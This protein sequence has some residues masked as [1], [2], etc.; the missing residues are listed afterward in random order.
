M[1]KNTLQRA[2]DSLIIKHRILDNQFNNILQYLDNQFN[3]NLQ[4]LDNQ[5]NN[6]LQEYKTFANEF[7]HNQGPLDENLELLQA[8]ALSLFLELLSLFHL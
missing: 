8:L 1:R 6:N 4:Y 2:S 5:F 3:N 7:L